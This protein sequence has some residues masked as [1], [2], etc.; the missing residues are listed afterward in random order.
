MRRRSRESLASFSW[1]IPGRLAGSARPGLLRELTDDLTF[2]RSKGIARV[3]N[4]TTKVLPEAVAEAGFQVVHFPIADM[5]IPTPRACAS[6]CRSIVEEL[7]TRP[8][9]LHC[10]GGLGRTGTVAACCLVT[11][12]RGPK[13]ALAEVR[14]INPN[15]VQSPAQAAFIGHYAQW[16]E[17]GAEPSI[18]ALRKEA[19]S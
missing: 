5:G 1:F 16:I 9:L 6:L 15:Y 8:T 10:R 3:V 7:E 19:P 12:G 11:L 17:D 18:E 4:L 13:E 14:A 2:L